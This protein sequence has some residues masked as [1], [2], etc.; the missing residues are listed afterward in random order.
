[1][2]LDQHMYGST[3]WHLPSP[4]ST[5]KSGTFPES[6]LKTPKTEGFPQSHFTDAWATPQFNGQHTP[7]QTPS[8]TLS[9]PIDRPSSSYSIKPRTPEDPEFHVNHFVPNNLPLPPVEVSRRLSSSP[10]PSLVR[11]TGLSPAAGQPG[12]SRPVTMDFSQMQTPPPTRDANS[13]RRLQQSGGNEFATPATVI[14][15]TPHQMPTAEALFN[16]TPFGFTDVQF[17][18]SMMPFSNMGQVSG[19]PMPQSRLFWD[20]PNDGSHMDIDMPL[21]E[22]PFGPTPHKVEQ[23]FQW[24]AF[25]TP[26][27]PQM[28]SQTFQPLNN[29]V[30]PGPAPS[31]SNHA[32]DPS[33]SRSNSF[34]TSSASVDPSMLFSFS[35]Q[36]MNASF[37]T[38]P[39]QM[40]VNVLDRQPYETQL[41]DARQEQEVVKKARSLHSRSNT[42]SSSGSV[43][44]LRPGLQRSNTDSGFRKS[45]PSSSDSRM[46]V[47]NAGATIPR[48]S[49]PLKRQSGGALTSIPEIR[50]SRTRLVIDETGRARTETVAAGDDDNT[51]KVTQ[52]KPSQQD[53]RRQYPGLWDEDDSESEDDEPPATLSRN[54]S[55]TMIPQVQP[56]QRRASK[57]ARS[58]S[59]ALDR[60]NSFKI[61]R[62][63]SRPAAFDKASFEPVR[64]VRKAV[65]DNAH[66]RFS[67]MEFP[68]HALEDQTADPD[69]PG[70]A[71]GALKKVVA[72]RSGRVDRIPN[73]PTRAFHPPPQ[74]ST[75]SLTTTPSTVRS[76]S[77]SDSPSSTRCICARPD[78]GRPMLQCES[79]NKWLHMAC[80]G[81]R[82]N[83]VPPVYVCV[84]CTGS[85]PVARGRVRGPPMPAGAMIGMG[86][87]SPLGAKGPSFRR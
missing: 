30:P 84:F 45:R 81:L 83:N 41:R 78:D 20:Q 56:P 76:A 23:N 67:M 59:G 68:S 49:S 22:D 12:R 69:S 34:V 53:V 39:Q 19:P 77:S 17:S 47:P 70:D 61:P 58:D 27:Q 15:R 9:T 10:D 44:N 75:S 51:P 72:G 29:M 79:C 52:R 65:V 1:M 64:P 54:T 80:V 85:T 35:G 74:S 37:G 63:A 28:N 26:V 24:Q 5:P 21:G 46:A 2:T 6:T 8:F 62:P 87:E 86:I 66:R 43:E 55:F 48:R 36:D 11:K 31:F 16:Q 4:S 3:D 13:R 82:Q 40:N 33:Y 38:M 60:S 7:A 57:H 14:H 71:L 42:N 32:V 73:H 18:P 50:R 25:S